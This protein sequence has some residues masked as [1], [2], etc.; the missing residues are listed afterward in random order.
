MWVVQLAGDA[1]DLAALAQSLTGK[2]MNVSHD[3]QGYVLASDQFGE[4]DEAG[5]V[6]QK[7]EDL[8][9]VL[10]GASRLALGSIHSISVG[11]VYRR[12]MGGGRDTFVF[13]KPG[14]VRVRGFAPA[15]KLTHADGTVEEFHPA[16]PVRQWAG[17]ALKSDAV[18]KVFR[19]FAGGTLDWV[20][21]YRVLEIVVADVGGPDAID[22]NGWATKSSMKLFKH[23]ANSP[24]ALGPNARHGAETTQPPR[25]P[26]TISEARAL[27]NCIVHA[28]LRSKSP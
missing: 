5:A 3:G 17:V 16:D 15:L 26:M 20:N 6:H 21:L 4:N 18:T 19:V 13:P 27:V 25:Q 7:A 1:T 23:T 22:A 8:V 9:A 12:H 28:W 10:D 24:G 2:D 14:V 11:A